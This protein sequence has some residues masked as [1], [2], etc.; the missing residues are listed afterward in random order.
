MS[1]K[2]LSL[3][4]LCVLVAL[5]TVSPFKVGL[6]EA[7]S[8]DGHYVLDIKTSTE[9]H[10]K[11][12]LEMEKTEEMVGI[13]FW[14]E[15]R[16]AKGSVHVRVPPQHAAK[17]DAF[18]LKH[19]MEYEV[20]L[21]SLEDMI[22]HE[23]QVLANR[24]VFNERDEPSKLTLGQFH[25]I[26]EIYSYINSVANTYSKTVSPFNLGKSTQG[27]D[28]LGV[29]IGNPGQNKPKIVMHGCLHSREWVGCSTM[30]YIINELTENAGSYAHLLDKLDIYI[31]P[32]ANPDGYCFTWGPQRFWRKTLSGPYFARN[33]R[34]C[35][36]VDP[37]RNWDF[38]FKVAGFSENPCAET[39]PGI[40]A[41]SEPE[42]RLIAE[43]LA[44]HK[45]SIKAYFDI[46]AY[47]ELFMFPYGYAKTYPKNVATLYDIA[48]QA[49]DAINRVHG[50]QFKYGSIV[51]II[52][53]ASGSS[54]DYAKGVLGIEYTYA[55][56]LRPNRYTRP[57]F[58]VDQS[59]IIPAA[60]ET[61]A[62]LHVVLN[63]VAQG[64]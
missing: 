57:G 23:K 50:S 10:V 3:A 29:K 36:G 55:L 64:H 22:R 32:V 30:L 59:Q 46:H 8:Y 52:Y 63:Y 12:L 1:G 48:E 35:Y 21:M 7:Q 17:M 49:T 26:A 41:F 14:N 15:P 31:L 42:P 53:P 16:Q 6:P 28:L 25:N 43:F 2:L 58:M 60:E 24:T 19:D 40:T 47:G 39:F 61:W 18:L 56:E 33:G 13:D 9:A 27:R 4:S 45:D 5:G 37:N 51:D 11:A 62:G 54:I 20:M 34:E 44:A 38:K